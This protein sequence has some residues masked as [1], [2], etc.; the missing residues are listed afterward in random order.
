MSDFGDIAIS[1]NSQF[2]PNVHES[3][4]EDQIFWKTI[5]KNQF[6]PKNLKNFEKIRKNIF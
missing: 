2:Y 6:F 5:F 4:V 1:K 3:I